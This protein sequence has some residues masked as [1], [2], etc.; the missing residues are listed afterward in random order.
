MTKRKRITRKDTEHAAF[1]QAYPLSA[2]QVSVIGDG[3]K[4]NVGGTNVTLDGLQ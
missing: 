4:S 1:G 3:L 2:H